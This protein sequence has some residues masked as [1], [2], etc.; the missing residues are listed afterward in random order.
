[1]IDTRRTLRD[2][3]HSSPSYTLPAIFKH[4]IP[5]RIFGLPWRYSTPYG[6][7]RRSA[8]RSSR[9]IT[10]PFIGG[11]AITWRKTN[12]GYVPGLPPRQ[13]ISLS[14][15]YFGSC[16]PLFAS[17]LLQ[18][19]RETESTS[20]LSLTPRLGHWW[21]LRKHGTCGSQEQL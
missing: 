16:L 12:S 17:L 1:M 3:T 14:L 4:S 20:S 19:R 11:V 7:W 6:L 2:S 21:L 15:I 9:R 5:R 8:M 10:M 18:Y 13:P